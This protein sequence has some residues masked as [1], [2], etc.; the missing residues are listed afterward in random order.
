MIILVLQLSCVVRKWAFGH[1]QTAK[2]QAGLR[3][4]AVSPKL[5]C[6]PKVISRPTVCNSNQQ[7]FWW[8]CADAQARLKLCCL[9]M[10]KGSFSHDVAH[11]L[12]WFIF[13]WMIVNACIANMYEGCP[14][15]AYNRLILL[16]CDV[17]YYFNFRHNTTIAFH[18]SQ[19]IFSRK[20]TKISILNIVFER[21]VWPRGRRRIK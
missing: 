15:I 21:H 19:Q 17:R 3:I 16:V 11:V 14:K 2:L 20:Y 6:L 12:V 4:R 10:S 5:C 18:I 9:H 13:C 1:T 8:D 7:S